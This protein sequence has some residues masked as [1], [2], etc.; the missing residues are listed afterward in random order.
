MNSNMKHSIAR[1]LLNVRAVSFSPHTPYTFKSGIKSPVYVDN[2]VLVYFPDEW[3]SIVDG[4][5]SLINSHD[6]KYD[7]IA[8]V[9]VG[10]V[11]HSSALAYVSERPS[12]F[13]RKGSKQHGKG[14]QIE[15]GDIESKLVVLVE[16]HVT[17]GSS[18]IKAVQALRN[19]RAQVSDVLAIISYGLEEAVSSFERERLNLFTLT[20]FETLLQE[21][22]NLGVLTLE[23]IDQINLWFA[24]P[25]AWEKELA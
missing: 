1:A 14:K 13:I 17:T 24:D 23:Q 9:A 11:P 7:V 5:R 15:G 22:H 21:A 19:E 25:R 20:D 4:F 6:L 8:G 10:G 12:V 2:R 16:D 3:H 18:T